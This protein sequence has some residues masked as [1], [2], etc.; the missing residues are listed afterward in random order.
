MHALNLSEF[1]IT[2]KS[3]ES[4]TIESIRKRINALLY[5]IQT[6]MMFSI[7]YNKQLSAY[8]HANTLLEI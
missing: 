6:C 2:Q 1:W 7:L 5:E 4:F 8:I 3:I